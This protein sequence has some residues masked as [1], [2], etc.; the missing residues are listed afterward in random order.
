MANQ[1]LRDK[2]VG[3]WYG[4]RPRRVDDAVHRA[5]PWLPSADRLQ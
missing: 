2:G 4:G 3:D 1:A 5:I